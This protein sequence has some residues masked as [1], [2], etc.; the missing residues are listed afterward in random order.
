MTPDEYQRVREAFLAARDLSPQDQI[1]FLKQAGKGDMSILAEVRS[2]L[3]NADKANTFLQTPAL[4]RSFAL[5]GPEKLLDDSSWPGAELKTSGPA[6]NSGGLP[7]R[8]GQY[9]IIDI[10]GSGGMGVV[11]RAEQDNP[12]RT[13]A[14]K[15][16]R[17]G[18]ES[19]ETLKRFEYEGQILGSL[20]HPGI[21]QVF[22][23]GTADSSHGPQPFFAMELIQGEPLGEYLRRRQPSI[24]Q[25]I[26]LLARVCDAVQH[27]HQKGIVHR[28]LKPANILV[29]DETAETGRGMATRAAIPDVGQ[30][31]ILDFGVARAT[32]ADVRTTT[33]QTAVGQLVGTVAYMSPEQVTGDP[34]Q[35]DTRSD[36]YALGVIGYEMLAGCLPI[37]VSGMTIPQA[38][39]AIA[40]QEPPALR[41]INRALGGDL[42][43]IFHTALEKDKEHR[44][45]SASDLSTDLRRYLTDQPILA[46]RATAFYQLRKFTRRNRLLVFSGAAVALALV[47]GTIVSTSLAT[48]AIDAEELAQARLT[49]TEDAL[50]QANTETHRAL[51]YRD[52]LVSMLEQVGPNVAQGRDVSLLRD[53]LDTAAA[54]IEIELADYPDVQAGIHQVIGTVY[55]GISAYD[56]AEPH[57]QTAYDLYTE[58]RGPD[59]AD[60][61]ATLAALGQLRW[62]QG[63]LDEAAEAYQT[64]ITGRNGTLGEEHRDTL[65][66]RYDLAGI[67]KD[68]GR[69]DEAEAELRDLLEEMRTHLD[70]DDEILLDATN[71][72][73]TLALE[74]GR[75]PEAEQ[76]LR[77][78]LERRTATLGLHHP[79]RLRVLR[80][81][82]VVVKEQGDLAAAEEL[83]RTSR[84]LNREVFGD[85][86]HDT[87]QAT[88]NLAS[89]LR[90]AGKFDEAEPVA[91]EAVTQSRTVLGP[92]HPDTLKAISHLGIILR[93]SGQLDEARTYLEDAVT[94]SEKL[95]GPHD[96][97]TLNSLSSLA[98]LLVELEELA[99]AE[100]IMH[101][102][103]DGLRAAHG[104]RA[105][106][107]LAAMNNLGSLL[108][109]LGKLDE[110][111]ELLLDTIRLVDE[112]AP[113]GHW[114]RWAVRGAHGECLIRQERYQEAEE[115]L[116]ECHARLSESLGPEHY[117]V[118]G[119]AK[120]LADLYEAWGR[121]EQAAEYAEPPAE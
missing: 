58:L 35:L 76:L 74:H 2:L 16:I 100:T 45:Q 66:A 94:L 75:L 64:L 21:A 46:R 81:L 41:S 111:D 106:H 23:A 115:V 83:T 51:A 24:E 43:V 4:G 109:Q 18:A 99:E 79:A 14:L 28:D 33:L 52:F 34:R 71:G 9:R 13:V 73:A 101:R 90:E 96:Q 117:R 50:A 85:G 89:I 7:E 8:I 6:L 57:L 61:L 104:E 95:W 107:T 103:V 113:P 40:E 15:V 78:V 12:R 11:Y 88:I 91:R 29:A 49:Q 10:L 44:Y 102:V 70:A 77:H 65:S 63:R 82:A 42:D 59:H 62:S 84:D 92:E 30:P 110:A 17:P 60:T 72:L 119:N 114:F 22:E 116:L 38:I 93:N 80:N 48:W 32:D 36:V 25:R 47:A 56:E 54:D 26:E 86:H 108:V 97:R 27:A 121:P 118:R 98:G 19:R 87:I 67:W 20:Q 112:V 69:L 5:D 37:D 1:E 3:D 53:V 120:K 68:Q 39:R 31:K 55:R 105:F